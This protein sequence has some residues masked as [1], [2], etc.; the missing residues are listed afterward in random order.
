MRESKIERKLV[1]YCR[2]KKVLCYKFSSPARVG[3]PDRILVFPGGR[4][5]F[6]E[7]KATGQRPTLLQFR[8]LVKL[9]KQGAIARWADSFEMCQRL[10]APYLPGFHTDEFTKFI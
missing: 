10:L 5:M 1:D 7:L 8:E 3:V 4:A 6:L 2:K 9:E